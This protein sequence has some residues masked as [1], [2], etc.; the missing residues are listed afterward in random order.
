MTNSISSTSI[1]HADQLSQQ[2]IRQP[3]P[4]T[5]APKNSSVP[6]DTVS[7]KSTGDVDHDGDSH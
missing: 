5:E 2:A 6:Q 3:Q 7:L 4:K 1:N